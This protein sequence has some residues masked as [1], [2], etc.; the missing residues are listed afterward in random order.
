LHLSA[1]AARAEVDLR[2]RNQQFGLPP[3]SG[4]FQ[5]GVP[6]GMQVEEVP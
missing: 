4:A 3:P 2:L 6:K 1:P 5:L